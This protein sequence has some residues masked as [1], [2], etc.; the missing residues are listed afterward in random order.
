MT[1]F[2]YLTSEDDGVELE[3]S[4]DDL[5]QCAHAIFEIQAREDGLDV[6]IDW[7]AGVFE[8]EA[9][10]NILSLLWGNQE[11]DYFKYMFK[12]KSSDSDVIAAAEQMAID[13]H[14]L[15]GFNNE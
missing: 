7:L 13:A 11:N 1:T 9:I 5:I 2:T 4:D 12:S 8:K 15:E 3:Y 14:N 6:A 10:E